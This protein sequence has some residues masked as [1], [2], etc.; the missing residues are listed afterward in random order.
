MKHCPGHHP[1]LLPVFLL[2][3]VFCIPWMMTGQDQQ[4]KLHKTK[5]QLEEE[6]RYTNKLLEETQ[7]SKA[8][9]LTK[10]N[11]LKRQIERREALID[12]IN[13]DLTRIQGEM[14][15]Q[16]HELNRM[17]AELSKMKDEYAKM[18]YYS[19]KNLNTNNRLL[20]IF[21][22]S[23]FNQAMNRLMYYRQYSSYR[24]LQAEQIRSTQMVVNLKQRELESIRG[25]KL[26]LAQEKELEKVRLSKEREEK[27]KSVKELSK[28]ETQLMA[29]LKQKQQ[30]AA[31]L[32]R[33]IEKLIAEEVRKAA[34]KARKAEKSATTPKMETRKTDIM[35]THS[36]V[37]LSNNFAANKGKLPWPSEKGVITGSFG[38]HNHPVLKY[39]KVK[40]NG[41]DIA[42]EQ[43]S[44]V[45]SVF[46]G[47]VSRVM[48]MQNLHSV[49]IIRHG[50]YLTVYS[51][52]AEVYVKDGQEV[53]T[54]QAI[55]K[56]FT[57]TEES[58][59]E[60]HFEIWL[61]K[62][63]QNPQEWLAGVN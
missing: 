47:K 58:R 11:M 1:Y 8:A 54:R 62:T 33:E 10:I 23:D 60:L 5:K 44:P 32:Q 48:N 21:S 41:V 3:V 59:T 52:L 50:E 13:N 20:F 57:N 22:A 25:E 36:E 61:G 40:N 19:Y 7:K 12:V 49:V 4:S 27:D 31:K 37:Q 29:T 35:L 39:V 28:K 46:S 38:E 6:I 53:T 2:L 55:G 34:E 26:R 18:I 9:S 63:I 30:A 51:N 42:T 16:D 45:R 43:G 24:R 14:N 56:V 17:N 15:V